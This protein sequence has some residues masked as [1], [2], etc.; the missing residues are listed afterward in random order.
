MNSFD[1]LKTQ[2]F[3][4][5]LALREVH[6]GDTYGPHV[7]TVLN[8][9]DDELAAL[10]IAVR[11]NSAAFDLAWG[12]RPQGYGTKITAVLD[13]LGLPQDANLHNPNFCEIVEI[14]RRAYLTHYI[15]GYQP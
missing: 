13:H 9:Y 12:C 11:D 7:R 3:D 1:I 15:K 5:I 2:A 6:T 14:F 4:T 10:N 8:K